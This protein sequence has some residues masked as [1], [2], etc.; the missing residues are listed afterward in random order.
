MNI[1]HMF[2]QRQCEFEWRELVER[3]K[4]GIVHKFDIFFL[5]AQIFI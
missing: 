1:I 4:R 2:K 3:Y 5:W